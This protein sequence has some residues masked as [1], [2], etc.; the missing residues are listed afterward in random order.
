MKNLS[1]RKYVSKVIK[2]TLY[3]LFLILILLIFMYSKSPI[4]PIIWEPS[5]NP[6]LTGNFSV[7]TKLEPINQILKG[8]GIG[9]EDIAKGPDG[10]FY[11]GYR[12]GRILRFNLKG[13][14]DIYANT[15]GKPLGIDFDHAGNLIVAD[16][17]RGL[18]SID[19]DKNITVLT[20]NV[21]GKK[22]LFV[23]DLDIASDGTIWFSDA[24]ELY[25]YNNSIYSLLENRATGRLLSY[26][27]LTNDTKVHLNGLHFANGVALGP[28][29]EYV[30]VNETGGA[31]IKRLWL[32][33]DNKNKVD[34]FIDALPGF[35]D[36]ISFNGIDTFW[37][38][39]PAIR[40]PV[41]DALADKPFI[42]KLIGGLPAQLLT[43]KNSNGLILGLN[44]S[45]EV[46]HNFQDKQSPIVTLTSVNQWEKTLL[47]GSLNSDFIATLDLMRIS[48]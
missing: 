27:P 2:L 37:V 43:P 31:K 14:Y 24:T 32:K 34:Y 5:L 25:T 19:Q 12:D 7:N 20:D 23:D 40:Q 9:G 35:P 42:R 1:T 28:E 15:N 36:N 8:V 45:G 17:E 6:G 16:A 3:L 11:T 26:S 46:I 30:L 33:G 47:I 22:M 48:H 4:N 18:L 21:N 44:L 41:I 29:E 10:Y 13:K 39:L 38:A